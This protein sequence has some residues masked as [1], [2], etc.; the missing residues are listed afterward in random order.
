MGHKRVVILLATLL[1]SDEPPAIPVK[2]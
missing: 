2:P 1:R